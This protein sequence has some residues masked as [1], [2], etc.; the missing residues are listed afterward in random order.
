MDSKIKLTHLSWS[1]KHATLLGPHFVSHSTLL[2]FSY[3]NCGLIGDKYNDLNR[4]LNEFL[5]DFKLPLLFILTKT[6][7]IND[8]KKH[9]YIINN[10]LEN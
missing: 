10:N 8:I 5:F 3:L 7:I 6:V 1:S 2:N 4:S 9:N